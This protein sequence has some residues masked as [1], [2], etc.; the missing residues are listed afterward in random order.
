MYYVWRVG[1][2]SSTV[3][4]QLCPILQQLQLWKVVFRRQSLPEVLLQGG[5]TAEIVEMK[6]LWII[7]QH[8]AKSVLQYSGTLFK[9]W[10]KLRF[11]SSQN[12]RCSTIRI[13]LIL[14]SYTGSTRSQTFYYYLVSLLFSRSDQHMNYQDSDRSID[15]IRFYCYIICVSNDP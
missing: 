15:Q 7:V 4:G 2:V 13:Y 12:L 11:L 10:L 6:L 9:V 8:S 3:P 14:G 1:H 5:G